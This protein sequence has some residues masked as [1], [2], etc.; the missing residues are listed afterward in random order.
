MSYLSAGRMRINLVTL[1]LSLLS[2]VILSILLGLLARRLG[3]SVVY[4][5]HEIDSLYRSWLEKE[6]P[7]RE[8]VAIITGST[9]GL[10]KGIA[11]ELYLRYGATVILASRS[12]EK[13]KTVIEEFEE[14]CKQ[15]SCSGRLV[16]NILDTSDLESVKRFANWFLMNF[17]Y[18]TFLVNNA[19]IHYSGIG[20]MDPR[21]MDMATVSKQG[22]YSLYILYHIQT[23]HTIHTIHNT[24][25]IPYTHCTHYT[26]Y[27]HTIYHIHTIHTI[28]TVHTVHTIHTIHTIPR[29]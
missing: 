18:C 3:P 21:N 24:H 23:I 26:H 8:V 15:D 7:G 20:M 9:S 10:G 22:V 27:T 1:F 12:M 16:F 5:Q 2:P 6:E 11:K 14:L 19:G 25:Y 13:I 28:H 17:E 4:P 29:L